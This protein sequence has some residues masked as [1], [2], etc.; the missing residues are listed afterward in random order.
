MQL[1]TRHA[2]AR[3]IELREE[4]CADLTCFLERSLEIHKGVNLLLRCSTTVL[5]SAWRRSTHTFQGFGWIQ[6]GS[7]FRPEIALLDE[8]P[9]ASRESLMTESREKLAAAQASLRRYVQSGGKQDSALYRRFVRDL[10]YAARGLFDLRGGRD[11]HVK[12]SDSPHW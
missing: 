1:T 12:M 7:S 3:E 10:Q 8:Y 6:V 9:M 5:V 4:Q 11:D 2:P